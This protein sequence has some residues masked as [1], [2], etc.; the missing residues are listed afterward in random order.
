MDKLFDTKRTYIGYAGEE[1]IDMCIPVVKVSDITG[2][3][4]ESLTRDENGRL[5]TFVWKNVA[6]NLDMIDVVMY[7]NHIFNPFA[8]KEGSILNIPSDNDKVYHSSDE[9]T[10]P[11]GSIHS[12]NVKGEKSMSY[13]DTVAYLGKKG[14]G[15]K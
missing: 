3:A 2:N 7:A 1:Y 13:A 4:V 5:D 15:I 10:L 14:L 11:D 12:K 6:Q 8:V 9:P